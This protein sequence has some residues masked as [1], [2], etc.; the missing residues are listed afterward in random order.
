MPSKTTSH[1]INLSVAYFS[2]TP[3]GQIGLA[4]SDTGLAFLEMQTT[5]QLFEANLRSKGFLLQ[6]QQTPLLLEALEQLRAYFNGTLK[7]FDLPID[8]NRFTP[9]QEQVLRKTFAIPYGQVKTYAQIAQEVGKPR[10][11]RA[12]GQVEA[13][14]PLPIIIPCH[15]VIGSDGSLHGYGAPGGLETKARLLKLE[16]VSV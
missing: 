12:V 7:V 6:P 2:Q 8:W 14:N 4:A 1:L 10:A 13:H 11:A 15:R 3:F 16:G 5:P 9:F